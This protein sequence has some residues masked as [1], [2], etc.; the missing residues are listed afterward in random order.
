[1]K[2]KTF[3]ISF[4]ISYRKLLFVLVII[5]NLFNK[6]CKVYKRNI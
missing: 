1:M 5:Q 4:A 3:K 2:I 6:I